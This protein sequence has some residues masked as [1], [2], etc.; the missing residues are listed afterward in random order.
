MTVSDLC[1]FLTVPWTGLQCVIV[2]LPGHTHLLLEIVKRKLHMAE[3]LKFP[4]SWTLEIQF[5][6]LLDAYKNE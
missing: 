5:L 2:L 6:N 4:K 1:L 3:S